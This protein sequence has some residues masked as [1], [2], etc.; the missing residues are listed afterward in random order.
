[1][2]RDIIEALLEDVIEITW[3]LD[4][5]MESGDIQK[6]D[7]IID[8]FG[9][10]GIKNEIIQIARDFE[11]KFPFET[12]WED[13]ELDYIIEIEKFAKEKLIEVFGKENYE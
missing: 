12:S 9:S 10:S 13:T 1:M 2:S 6:W 3:M 4:G 5:L 8:T 11:K 7:D